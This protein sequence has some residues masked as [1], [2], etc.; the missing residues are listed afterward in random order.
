M[1][2]ISWRST[3]FLGLSKVMI[4]AGSRMRLVNMEMMSVVDVSN[5]SATV[6]PKSGEC[7]NYKARKQHY[8]SV[9][10][11]LSCFEDTFTY[12]PGNKKSCGQ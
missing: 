10:N 8:R 12:R 6:P 5:P 1:S 2:S 9:D 3:D 11:A 7:E 4:S